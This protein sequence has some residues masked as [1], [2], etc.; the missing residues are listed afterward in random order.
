MID[1]GRKE[2]RGRSF[3]TNTLPSFLF[4]S[5]NS[6]TVKY[7]EVREREMFSKK[8][9]L[10]ALSRIK[11]LSKFRK[12]QIA[13]MIID[14]IDPEIGISEKIN[15]PNFRT[16]FERELD[17]LEKIGAQVLTILDDGYP[18]L[19]KE[20]PDAPILVYAKGPL[21]IKEETIGVVGSRKASYEGMNL[22]EKIGETLSSLGVTVIS[23]LARGIDTSAHKGGL[24]GKGKTVAVLGCGIDVCYPAENRWLYEK[25]SHEG[26]LLSEY[27]PG[28]PPISYHF[29]ERNRIIAGMSKA[30]LV[31]EAPR[32]SGALITARLALDYGRDVMAIPG[33]VFDEAYSGTNLLIKEG[34]RLVD[35]TEDILEF[36]FP[37]IRRE[38]K[39]ASELENEEEIVYSIIGE[40]RTH[41]DEI[42][43]KS[44]MDASKV[45]GILTKLEMKGV[46]RS[47]PGGFY[48]R[49]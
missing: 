44:R 24:K 35:R 10:F 40:R 13:Q 3:S 5:E 27:P 14:G 29:P 46:V 22:A 39:G 33:S 7:S 37:H 8:I 48:L 31:V 18:L 6:N 9:S 17:Y 16:E 4:I 42:I 36:S 21:K 2:N 23:G 47:F 49:V 12:R 45:L 20:I 26:L 1:G 11:G 28:E 19:L 43:M 34:A 30:V 15:D 38:R 41:I 25:I 32:K